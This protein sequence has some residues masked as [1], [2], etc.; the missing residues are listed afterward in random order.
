[1]S[2]P[3][4]VEI[5]VNETEVIVRTRR[6]ILCTLI[7]LQINI[8]PFPQNLSTVAYKR[9]AYKKNRVHQE[10]EEYINFRVQQ[11]I[12]MECVHLPISVSILP[13]LVY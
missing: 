11:V 4:F 5:P 8:S 9:V 6:I 3:C 7:L 13:P 2:L 10:G 12:G 1:M